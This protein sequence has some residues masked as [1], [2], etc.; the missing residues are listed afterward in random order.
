MRF[1]KIVALSFLA[2]TIVLLGLIILA[3]TKRV[4]IMVVGKDDTKSVTIPFKVAA[5]AG[6]RIIKGTVT[7]TAFSF[8]ATFYPTG[9]K[10][11]EA[12]A[13]GTATIYN[14]TG[15]DQPLVKTTRLLSP[16]GVLFRL[17]ERTLVPAG[18]SVNAPVYADQPGEG[19]NIAAT[20]FTIP[21]LP[22]EKQK[23]IYAESSAPMSG[24]V[25]RVGV[26]SPED[27]KAAEAGYRDKLVQAYQA[28]A[29]AGT[30]TPLVAVVRSAATVSD[31]VGAEVSEFTLRGENELAV[32]SY[33]Q[34]ALAELVARELQSALAA[35]VEKALPGERMPTV[36][37]V[38]ADP[39]AG[40]AELTATTD[41]TV[42]IDP[43]VDKLAAQNFFGKNK[44]EIERYVLGLPHVS[45]VAVKFSPAWLRS[46]PDN[47]ERI[48]VVVKK[49]E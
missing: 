10:T 37:V 2:L 18:G 7:S 39:A 5:V 42:T 4:E 45:T 47:P 21:G 16:A 46:A 3:T 11:V 19:G 35:D 23:V 26:L 41:V 15:A 9:T 12:I 29:P 22:E 1:Y 36:A 24:G 40:A 31:S 17:S 33:D 28:G 34:S 20:A 30:G 43:T 13:T 48:K 14:K 38:T 25:R 27:L 6:E 44:D 49:V 32:V 8:A